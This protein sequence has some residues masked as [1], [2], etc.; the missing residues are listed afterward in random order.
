ML[1]DNAFLMVFSNEKTTS[2]T[3]STFMYKTSFQTYMVQ[4]LYIKRFEEK[5]FREEIKI[6]L[7]QQRW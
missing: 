4:Y 6:I 7:G 1:S 5:Y 2:N 3:A